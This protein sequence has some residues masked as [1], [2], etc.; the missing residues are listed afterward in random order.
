[1]ILIGN[2]SDRINIITLLIIKDHINIIIL[3]ITTDLNIGC[4]KSKNDD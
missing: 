3:L 1:M 2:D 4:P